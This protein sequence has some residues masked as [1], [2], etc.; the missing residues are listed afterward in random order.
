MVKKYTK[1]T[2][3]HTKKNILHKKR[4]NSKKRGLRGGAIDTTPKIDSDG[5]HGIT[6]L[7]T[8]SREKDLTEDVCSQWFNKIHGLNTDTKLKA[9]KPDRTLKTTSTGR[10]DYDICSNKLNDKSIEQFNQIMEQAKKQG[11]K[12]VSTNLSQSNLSEVE[13]KERKEEIFKTELK[14]NTTENGKDGEPYYVGLTLDDCVAVRTPFMVRGEKTP[15][16]E[17]SIYSPAATTE[18]QSG[19]TSTPD[20]TLVGTFTQL[21]ISFLL[22][23]AKQ[24]TPFSFASFYN[25]GERKPYF[26]DYLS[27]LENVKEKFGPEVEIDSRNAQ[28]EKFRSLESSILRRFGKSA[29]CKIVL[30]AGNVGIQIQDP[31]NGDAIFVLPSQLNGAEY[32]SPQQAKT[33]KLNDYKSDPTAGPL[34]QL[35]FHPVVAQFVMDHAERDLPSG[36]NFTSDFLVINAIDK[37]IEELQFLG[38][39]SLTLNNGYLIV[40]ANLKSGEELDLTDSQNHENP[41]QNAIAI[42]D[43]LSTSLKVLQTEDVPTSG[44]KPPPKYL[45]DHNGY[46]EFNSDSTTKATPIYAS[47]VPLQYDAK[48]NPEKSML[49]YCVAGFDLV[50]QY[51]G[52]MVSA[53]NKKKQRANLFIFVFFIVGYNF[54]LKS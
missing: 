19:G 46:K 49:Q 3:R 42:F 23:V 44:L 36:E 16:F 47:A 26:S 27:C 25:K 43:S 28:S 45:N 17:Y 53:Y 2:F 35:S 10:K 54:Y 41:S 5:L 14:S 1:D 12:V 48:I 18:P 50:A 34:G 51:F 20:G 37:V 8:F 24:E 4:V 21:P 22:R 7:V 52:A 29:Q 31:V 32:K 15:F 40:P 13:G 39:T 38:I 9:F 6:K 11:E 30:V 33:I